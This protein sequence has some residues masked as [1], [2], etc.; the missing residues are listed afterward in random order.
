MTLKFT[1]KT[2][3]VLKIDSF[4]APHVTGGYAIRNPCMTMSEGFTMIGMYLTM[5]NLESHVRK[6][7]SAGWGR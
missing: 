6:M 1:W 3:T 2:Y 5:R 4:S 7:E